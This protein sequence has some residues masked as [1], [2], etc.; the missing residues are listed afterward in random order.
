[1]LLHLITI[2]KLKVYDRIFT[3]LMGTSNLGSYSL[4]PYD[5]LLR[6][7]KPPN[8]EFNSE[9]I[10]IHLDGKEMNPILFKMT[11]GLGLVT[12]QELVREHVG[13]I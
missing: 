7:A 2:I 3:T 12:V 9:K 13:L 4:R 6:G 5:R 8:R 10:L 11:F 1:M